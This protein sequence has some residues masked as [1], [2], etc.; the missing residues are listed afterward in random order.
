M[1]TKPELKITNPYALDDAQFQAAV[2]LLKAQKPIIGEYWS[3]YTKAVQSFESGNTV[4]GTSW[5]VIVNLVNGGKKAKVNSIVPSEGSTGWSDTWMISSKAQHPNCM[6]KWMDHII[7][8]SVNA[9]V[10]EWFGEAPS[11]P[12]RAP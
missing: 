4:I 11:Q 8:P 1:K 7:S 5:Q 10:A 2:D 3:D 6:Y 12:L 9:Q